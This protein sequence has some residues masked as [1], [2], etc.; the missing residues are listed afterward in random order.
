MGLI[1]FK[2]RTQDQ[3]YGLGG[4]KIVRPI[5]GLVMLARIL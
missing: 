4:S 1:V 2:T 3:K 5:I